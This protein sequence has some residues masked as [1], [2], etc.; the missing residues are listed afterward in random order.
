M[1]PPDETTRLFIDAWKLMVGRLPTGRFAHADGVASCLGHV[2]MP[3]LN[4]CFHDGPLGDRSAVDRYLSAVG[5]RTASCPHPSLTVLCEDWAP[6]GWEADAAAHGLVTAMCLTGME[7]DGILPA[8]RPAPAL[9]LRRID[10]DDLART[11]A[12][13]N[14]RAYGM[15][16]A[17]GD[18]ISNMH[19]WRDD[20]H[21]Y[22]AFVD[23]RP[24]SC[25]AAF[26]VDGTV[27]IALVATEP[28]LHGKGYGETVMRHAIAAGQRAMGVTR[29][30]LHATDAGQP[31]YRAMG[32]APSARFAVLTKAD[33]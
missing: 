31:L 20:S 11:A 19:L 21:G 27:Y 5:Q 7:A 1:T 25:A 28:D 33:H 3:F 10:N 17:L 4:L 23:G 30:T 24:V 29:T 12:L 32:Y 26:P 8:R 6:A 16:E 14:M 2:P 9:D 13:I 18:C 15:P 22:V